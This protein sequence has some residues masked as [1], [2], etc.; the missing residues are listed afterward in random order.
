MSPL[1]AGWRFLVSK[2]IAIGLILLLGALTLVGTLI[3]QLPDA[4]R[5]D[6]LATAAWVDGIRPRFGAATDWMWRLQ[7]FTVF[8]SLTF[9]CAAAVL[10]L[11]TLAC[12]V[13]RSPA[14]WRQVAHPPRHAPGH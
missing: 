7:A 12:T 11:S 4:A 1:R 8:H 10:G 14:L 2:V 5:G 13:N 6:A 9:T 3:P